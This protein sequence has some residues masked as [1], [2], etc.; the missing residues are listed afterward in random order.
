[1]GF[2]AL[3]QSKMIPF[4]STDAYNLNFQIFS[5]IKKEAEEASWLLALEKGVAPD[6]AEAAGWKRTHIVA[7]EHDQYPDYE[8]TA[9]AAIFTAKKLGMKR[10]MHLLAIAPNASSSILCGNT[11]PSIEPFSA[12]SFSQKTENGTHVYK[13][14]AFQRL[15]EQ[16]GLGEDAITSVWRSVGA[17]KGS[18]QH[19]DILTPEEKE[20]FKTAFEINQEWVVAHAAVRQK[21]I[22]QAQSVNLFFSTPI[23]VAYLHRVHYRAWKDGLKTLYY[24]RQSV[25][26]KTEDVGKKVERIHLTEDKKDDTFKQTQ[27]S[28]E[29]PGGYKIDCYGCEG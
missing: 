19:L 25:S 28:T 24:L 8:P 21:F 4:E 17:K 2:H 9:K 10:N 7:T 18:V 3:L 14:R 20:V 22:C 23:D 15:L 29:L 27:F 26:T 16:K 12:V 6:Y 1:M 13:N 11:S 5:K